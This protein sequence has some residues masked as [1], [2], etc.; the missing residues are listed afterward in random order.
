VILHSF[1]NA[2]KVLTRIAVGTT[3]SSVHYLSVS[4]KKAI[5]NP[6]NFHFFF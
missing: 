2:L 5:G 6:V 1:V 4:M 3:V